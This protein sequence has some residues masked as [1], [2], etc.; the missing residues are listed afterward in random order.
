M[1]FADRGF[2]VQGLGSAVKG[3]TR[4]YRTKD[5]PACHYK[6]TCQCQSHVVQSRRDVIPCDA[7]CDI[8]ALTRHTPE[9]FRR[10]VSSTTTLVTTRLMRPA[11]RRNNAAIVEYEEHCDR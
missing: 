3:R 4:D 1:P 5:C 11:K 10:L 9:D 2:M 6:H 8:A 7:A